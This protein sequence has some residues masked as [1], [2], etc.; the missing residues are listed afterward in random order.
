MEIKK[1][2]EKIDTLDR[3]IVKLLVE[4]MNLSAEIAS[5]KK[6]NAIPLFDKTREEDLLE[7]IVSLSGDV[8]DITSSGQF[9]NIKLDGLYLR[10]PISVCDSEDGF[11]TL[12]Y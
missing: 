5:Y 6:A 11:L 9:V 10:R 4:R 12:I 2:R 7:K 3:E 8:S 1:S